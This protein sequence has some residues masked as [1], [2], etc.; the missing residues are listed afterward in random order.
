MIGLVAFGERFNSFSEKEEN[1]QSRSSKVISA[2]YNS[3]SGIF[4]LDKGFIWKFINTP[5][6]RKLADAQSYLEKYV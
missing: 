3:N 5:L 1:A 4:K 2:A 6:Y